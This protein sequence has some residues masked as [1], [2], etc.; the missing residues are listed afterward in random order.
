MSRVIELTAQN[1]AQEVLQ[2]A[3]PV[4]VDFWAPWCGPCRMM[5]PILEE[6][7]DTF[8][9]SLKI[10]KLNVDEPAHQELAMQ[11]RIQGVPNMQIFKGGKMVKEL[12]GFRPKEVLLAEL[13]QMI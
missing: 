9:E 13:K 6:I 10:A 12:V 11:Y 2:S 4:L 3:V 5:A 8:G 1:F 7:A